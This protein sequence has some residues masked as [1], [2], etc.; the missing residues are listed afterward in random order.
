MSETHLGSFSVGA[1]GSVTVNPGQIYFNTKVMKKGWRY[2][3]WHVAFH[4]GSLNLQLFGGKK[5]HWMLPHVTLELWCHQHVGVW[6]HGLNLANFTAFLVKKKASY[7]IDSHFLSS[8]VFYKKIDKL[9]KHKNI[10]HIIVD[11][12]PCAQHICYMLWDCAWS[13][14]C[15]ELIL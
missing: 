7:S 3:L 10:N 4:S 8:H 6:C 11:L 1:R 2:N 15:V 13:C 5:D 14:S 9:I 12:L